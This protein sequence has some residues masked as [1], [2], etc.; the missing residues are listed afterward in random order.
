M[1]GESGVHLYILKGGR[2]DWVCV[3]LR[4]VNVGGWDGEKMGKV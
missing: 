1:D 4:E 2:W 3:L